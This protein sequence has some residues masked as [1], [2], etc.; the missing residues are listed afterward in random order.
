[1]KENEKIFVTGADGMLGSSICRELI[2]QGYG[3][4]AMCLPQSKSNTLQGLPLE[5]VYGNILDKDFLL[6]EMQDCSHVI[7]IA[8]LTTVWPR[9]LQIIQ[10]VNYQGAVHVADVAEYYNMQ[11]MVHIGTANSFGHGSKEE[12]GNEQTP[13]SSSTYGMDYI[14]SKYRVQQ[15][16][17]NRH[18]ERQ[19]PIV[20]INPTFMIGPFDSG[21]SSGQMLIGLYNGIIPAY[22]QG[23]KNFVCS[24]DVAVAA[25][26]ALK[27][28]RTGACYI[29]GNENLSFREFFMKASNTLGIPFTMR[30]APQL[31]ILLFGAFNSCVAS[32][33]G[34]TPKVSYTMARMAGVDQYFSSAKAQ[35]E[36]N[37]PQTP[38]EE[39]IKQCVDWFKANNYI[40]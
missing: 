32:V 10:E 4:K 25:V 14:D 13:F 23:G 2:H 20:I 40:K 5:L 39:G 37:M 8:A 26:N 3:I 16:L 12:P 21:P 29:A 33:T 36:L 34:K 6:R 19:F 30:A 1:V 18:A 31:L 27:M 22:S 35:Q 15:L 17:L 11:R 38:I 24:T 9:R 7:H 28:G